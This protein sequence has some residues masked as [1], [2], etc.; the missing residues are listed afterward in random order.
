[1]L[2][3]FLLRAEVAAQARLAVRAGI[4]QLV[5]EQQKIVAA[6]PTT[7]AAIPAAAA[8]LLGQTWVSAALEAAPRLPQITLAEVVA[9]AEQRQH[10]AA[11]RAQVALV[12]LAARA[13]LRGQMGPPQLPGGLDQ[14]ALA[15]AAAEAP[16]LEATPEQLAAQ[17]AQAQNIPLRLA[18]QRALAVAG[19]DLAQH[20]PEMAPTDRRG[21]FMEVADQELAIRELPEVAALVLKERSSS[22]IQFLCLVTFL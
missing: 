20:F 19:E 11:G 12:I 15:A 3:E 7:R 13:E 5:L 18:A 22:P 8:G 17:A 21:V 9:L 2:L 6:Q 4:L 10:Q 14:T 16:P 1:M